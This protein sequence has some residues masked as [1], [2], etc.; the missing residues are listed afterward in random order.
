MKTKHP[1][2]TAIVSG[3]SRI[4]TLG[5]LAVLMLFASAGCQKEARTAALDPAGTYNL[6]SVDGKN[7]PCSLTHEGVTPTIKSGVFTINTNGSCR[8]LITFSVPERGDM[9]REVNASYT[10]NGAELTMQWE[11][12][13]MTKGQIHGN[14]FSMTNEGMVFFYQ[15]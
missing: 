11:G 13:G 15:K 10:L 3:T 7:V 8:S 5:L 2:T 4:I 14:Q 6:V 12:A 9:N 1:S